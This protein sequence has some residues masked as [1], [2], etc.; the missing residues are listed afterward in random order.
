MSV[1]H[2]S[3]ETVSG[4]AQLGL[5]LRAGTAS[6]ASQPLVLPPMKLQKFLLLQN[7]NSSSDALL[8]GTP[9]EMCWEIPAGGQ[10]QLPID[11]ASDVSI[12]SAGTATLNWLAL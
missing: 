3:R 6:I 10:L 11:C 8:V 7:S 2:V 4:A 9:G 5:G 1:V 12:G